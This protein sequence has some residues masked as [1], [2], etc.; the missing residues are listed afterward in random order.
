MLMTVQFQG[1]IVMDLE[2]FLFPIYFH[3]N[4]FNDVVIYMAPPPLV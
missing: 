2:I 3:K 1:G 4:Y